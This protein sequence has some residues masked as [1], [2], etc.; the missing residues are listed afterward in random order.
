MLGSAPCQSQNFKSKLFSHP[1][2]G[3]AGSGVDC[4]LLRGGQDRFSRNKPDLGLF[5]AHTDR[6]VRGQVQPLAKPA[7]AVLTIR[8]SREWKLMTQS[9]PPGLSRGIAAW[10][11]SSTAE[12]SSLTA[13]RMAWKVRLAGCCFSRRA[14]GG[15]GA[16]DNLHQLQG[17]LNGLFLTPALDGGGNL[18]RITLFPVPVED[19]LQLLP[20]PGVHHVVAGERS[21]LVHSHVKRGVLH[22]GEAPGPVVQLGGRTRPDRRACRRLRPGSGNP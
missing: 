12:S 5:S 8:S 2:L 21:G 11:S 6:K 15:H 3:A 18:G 14:A 16:P 19:S 7:K 17:G 9:R 4:Q 13:M 10:S 22:I 1:Q 20:R